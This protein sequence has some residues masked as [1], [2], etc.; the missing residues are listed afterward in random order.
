MIELRKEVGFYLSFTDGEVFQGVDL[1]KEESDKTSA[2]AAALGATAAAETLP[3]QKVTSAY[4]GWDIVI[5]Q[6]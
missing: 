1:P 6:P 4:T 3:T 2:A 5:H